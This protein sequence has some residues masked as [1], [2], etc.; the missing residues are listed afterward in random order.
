MLELGVGL[1]ER[2]VKPA[3]L[4]RAEFRARVRIRARVRV[5]SFR[6]RVRVRSLW[7]GV[8]RRPQADPP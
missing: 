6:A 8:R 4:L 1:H 3:N 5:G 7:L 2:L